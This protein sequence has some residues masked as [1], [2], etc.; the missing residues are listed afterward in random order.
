MTISFRD[1]PADVRTPGFYGEFD[2]S[3]A[4]QGLSTVPHKVLLIGQGLATGTVAEGV[5]TLIPSGPAAEGYW[6][7][8]SHMAIMAHAYKENDAR[9][10]VWGI[11]L[12]D[13]ASGVQAAGKITFTGTAT[14]AGTVH[15]LIAGHS[16]PVV[17]ASGD[18]DEN[19]VTAAVAAITAYILVAKYGGFPLTGAINGVNADELDLTA[20]NDGLE[21][22]FLDL[23]LNYQ[24]GQQLPAGIT[25]VITPMASGATNPDVATAITSMGDEQS[26]TIVSSLT[27]DTNL[28]LIES[29]L[30]DRWEWD[31]QKEGSLFIGRAGTVGALTTYG[32]ARN[33]EFT[34]LAAPGEVP[35]PAFQ[36]AAEFGAIRAIVA[37]IDVAAPRTGRQL[38]L[39]LPPLVEDRYTRAERQILLTDGCATFTVNQSGAVQVER[40]ITT[41]QTN[42]SNLPDVSYL[43]QTTMDTLGYIRYQFRVRFATKYPDYKLASDG[44]RIPPG[45][46]IITPLIAKTEAIALSY[47]LQNDGKVENVDDWKDDIICVRNGSDNNRLDMQYPPNL[48]NQARV[49]A[50][51][52]SF[53]I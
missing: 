31:I 35:S 37:Q 1:I 16:I 21:G 7:R 42:A 15:L 30:S 41:Y 29:E 50:T 28:D 47:D 4:V 6:G 10:E 5:P 8:H 11:S 43:D 25:A 24:Q 49:I 45:Q 3:N 44:Q 23:R 13:H 48:M 46:K 32:N 26:N 33:S 12:D 52:F 40:M 2:N 36:F 20:V 18:T 53:K 27:D 17:V 38:K 51:K 39:C 9:T 19:V 14:E 34:C 22:N